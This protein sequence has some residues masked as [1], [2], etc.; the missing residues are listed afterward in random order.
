M[1]S[2]AK[3]EK[4]RKKA[5]AQKLLEE[6]QRVEK[7][8]AQ[9]APV[10][11]LSLPT[12]PATPVLVSCAL[13]H[14]STQSPFDTST[15]TLAD[16]SDLAD[17]PALPINTARVVATPTTPSR[18]PTTSPVAPREARTPPPPALPRFPIRF[19]P[20]QVLAEPPPLPP[21]QWPEHVRA[22]VYDPNPSWADDIPEP[23]AP[24]AV[25][26]IAHTPRNWASLR[27][28]GAH[29]W[30]AIRRRKRRLRAD[31]WERP[32]YHFEAAPPAEL[33]LPL[34]F[35]P[36]LE[37]RSQGI[38][39]RSA[40]LLGLVPLHPDDPIHPDDVPPDDLPVPS[41]CLFPEDHPPSEFPAETEYGP[42]VHQL[43]HAC[44]RALPPALDVASHLCDVVW[45]PMVYPDGSV[46]PNP[47][48]RLDLL[49]RL[50]PD[51]LVFLGAIAHMGHLEHHFALLFDPAITEF[52]RLWVH[53]CELIGEAG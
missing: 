11:T 26:S 28:V 23:V 32:T 48:A 17:A 4:A 13:P 16:N 3:K 31:C 7:E 43:A 29:P 18:T 12:G 22:F 19:L 46:D 49:A 8:T 35:E 51:H 52:A 34:P 25:M 5:R 53:H 38:L 14:S 36:P 42:V 37:V 15:L 10:S 44:S 24:S 27:S 1:T 39:L 41:L 33:L 9:R 2:G 21:L 20:Y 47:E 45:P 30:R 6:Q 40:D 50:S